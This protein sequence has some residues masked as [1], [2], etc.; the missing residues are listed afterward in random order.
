MIRTPKREQGLKILVI[1]ASLVILIA[2][3]RAAAGFFVPIVVL[4]AI[5]IFAICIST[6]YGLYGSVLS[7]IQ[8]TED[9]TVITAARRSIPA[10]A[11]AASMPAAFRPPCE[12]TMSVS[13]ES[14]L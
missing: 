10:A 14:I 1:L 8:A 6:V 3:L 7:V 4:I 2:G 13:R 11:R 5:A 12:S 9:N